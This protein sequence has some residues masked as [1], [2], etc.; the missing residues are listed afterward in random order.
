MGPWEEKE[1]DVEIL[2]SDREGGKRHRVWRGKFCFRYA[3]FKIT[4]KQF[5]NYLINTYKQWN[6]DARWLTRGVS[7]VVA[8]FPHSSKGWHRVKLSAF[9]GQVCRVSVEHDSLE[10][11]LEGS[12][13]VQG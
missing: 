1:D 10:G 5:K 6:W 3:K 7:W 2:A 13:Y 12:I 8:I 9:P 11:P 4:N